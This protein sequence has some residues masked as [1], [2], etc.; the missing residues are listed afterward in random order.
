MRIRHFLEE[1]LDWFT[2]PALAVWLLYASWSALSM[3]WLAYAVVGWF[4]GTFAE[5]VIHR[6]VLHG[7][8]WMS[9]HQRHHKAPLENTRFPLWQIPTYFL[10]IYFLCYMLTHPLDFAFFEG[11]VV[12]YISFFSVHWMQHHAPWVFPAFAIRHN[13]H[14]KVTVCNYGVTLDLWDRVFGT[15]RAANY[16]R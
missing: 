9:I 16:R 7:P 12:W 10:I 2:F 5:Y 4:V 14:H 13:A 8:W 11:W 3:K 1:Y 6:W 15:Y